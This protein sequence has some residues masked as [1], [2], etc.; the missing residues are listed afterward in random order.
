MSGRDVVIAVSI[1]LVGV[2]LL[3]GARMFAGG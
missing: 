3:V 1:V 2:L